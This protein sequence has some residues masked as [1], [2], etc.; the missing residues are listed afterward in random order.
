MGTK[1][2]TGMP[3][4]AQFTPHDNYY[5][6]FIA[7][8]TTRAKEQIRRVFRALNAEGRSYWKI[9]LDGWEECEAPFTS[10]TIVGMVGPEGEY[11]VKHVDRSGHS[12]ALLSG[13]FD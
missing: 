6:P 1:E 4:S 8:R 13:K 7:T 10:S 11:S 12:C 5:A 9:R 3:E 2:E